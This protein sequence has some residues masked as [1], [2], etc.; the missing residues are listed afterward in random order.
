MKK[1]MNFLKKNQML[2][3]VVLAV[4]VAC[5]FVAPKVMEK[6]DA[7]PAPVC[8]LFH[9][10]KCG[11]CK[12]MM[13]AWDSLGDKV[14]NVK[15]EKIEQA[16]MNEKAPKHNDVQGFPTIKYCPKGLDDKDSCKIFQGERSAEEFKKFIESQ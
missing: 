6:F 15:I 3:L 2:I 13:P 16:E 8:V 9:W 5:Y 11:H 7:D 4:V 14:G 12:S 10:E 1:M